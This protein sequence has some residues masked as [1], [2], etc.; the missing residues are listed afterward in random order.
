M[1]FARDFREKWMK[2]F[3][4]TQQSPMH[5]LSQLA[6]PPLQGGVVF[7]EALSEGP[8]GR[9]KEI[10][11]GV[12]G[13]L[14]M[15]AQG[16]ANAQFTRE[17]DGVLGNTLPAS[18]RY[19][20]D[21]IEVTPFTPNR[22]GLNPGGIAPPEQP[23]PIQVEPLNGTS[24]HDIAAF[25]TARYGTPQQF[26]AYMM[27]RLR[28]FEHQPPAGPT[29]QPQNAT[30]Q[31]RPFTESLGPGNV[32]PQPLSDPEPMPP[33]PPLTLSQQIARNVQARQP[34]TPQ[35]IAFREARQQREAEEAAL[36]QMLDEK[37]ARVM[38]EEY[39]Q[40]TQL[41]SNVPNPVDTPLGSRPTNENGQLHQMM[42][43]AQKAQ[44]QTVFD[45]Q[46]SKNQFRR[47]MEA[48]RGRLLG[49]RRWD[50]ER[51]P[52]YNLRV[53]DI[54]DDPKKLEKV[55]VLIQES[56]SISS[57]GIE[58]EGISGNR[59]IGPHSFKEPLKVDPA[60]FEYVFHGIFGKGRDVTYGIE[61]LKLGESTTNSFFENTAVQ[62]S[63]S[64]LMQTGKPQRINIDK[65]LLKT[66]GWYSEAT[67]G[68]VK[69]SIKGTLLLKNNQITFDGHIEQGKNSEVWTF[70]AGQRDFV[71]ERLTEFGRRLFFT[72][73]RTILTGRRRVIF[74]K[75]TI[76]PEQ[77]G[78]KR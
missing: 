40:P 5:R 16:V 67:I 57:G 47:I 3:L 6:P 23:Q 4:R 12:L 45:A 44:E 46:S 54:L 66:Q 74:S 7:D 43:R 49:D 72:Q 42:G 1:N 39:T 14:G 28:Q 50:L 24:P 2:E 78:N 61:H 51:T 33:E 21:P 8:W 11:Q 71:K 26:E 34:L 15:A 70:P 22:A 35:Q 75:N 64:E 18:T 56:T 65:V 20:V 17:P 9:L 31:D 13:G 48:Y 27:N 41:A 25:M 77:R 68:K 73:F 32:A 37:I 59:P 63:L 36:R 10:G 69:V 62:K 76:E 60:R 19:P 55:E 52:I 53:R 29:F 30:A 58:Y 38:R